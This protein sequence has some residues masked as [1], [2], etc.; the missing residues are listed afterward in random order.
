MHSI[1]QATAAYEPSVDLCRTGHGHQLCFVSFEP[2]A[3]RP[4]ER[5]G[6]LPVPGTEELRA[7]RE[8][9]DRAQRREKAGRLT[10]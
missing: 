10:F 7:L 9:I 4:Q 2:T 3:C 6:S 8:V 1:I 5:V